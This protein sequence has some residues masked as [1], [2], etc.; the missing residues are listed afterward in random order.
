MERICKYT[1]VDGNFSVHSRRDT[2]CQREEDGKKPTVMD[3]SWRSGYRL[4]IFVYFFWFHSWTQWRSSVFLISMNTPS[5]QI[6]VSEIPYS[7]NSW[8]QIWL[9]ECKSRSWN[10]WD[11]K[12]RKFSKTNA[13][14]WKNIV[15]G[16]EGLPLVT[17]WGSKRRTEMDCN[18]VNRNNPWVNSNTQ[19]HLGWGGGDFFY[20]RIWTHE[21]WRNDRF[22]NH[23]FAN[24]NL[25]I[26]TRTKIDAKTWGQVLFEKK[27]IH[28]SQSIKPYVNKENDIPYNGEIWKIPSSWSDPT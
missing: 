17:V 24:T 6:L 23:L 7:T 21:C 25:F 3:L 20:R 26:R 18:I 1:N 15:A 19:E 9:R 10:I 5:P 8:F 27:G 28:L 16:L 22:W 2:Q 12:S 4:M 13:F 14:V 11:E